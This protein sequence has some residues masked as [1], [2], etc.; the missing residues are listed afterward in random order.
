LRKDVIAIPSLLVCAGI[1]K[2]VHKMSGRIF[3][4]YDLVAI[5][6]NYIQF[7]AVRRGL[8]GSL[9]FLS[10]ANLVLGLYLTY[11]IYFI[12]FVS[13]AYLIL[14]GAAAVAGFFIP[15]VVVL[16]ALMLFWS[17][18]VSRTDLLIATILAAAGLAAVQGKIV[19]ASVCVAVGVTTIHEAVGIYGLP[20]LFAIMLDED[21]YK[22]MNSYSAAIGGTM[23]ITSFVS[24]AFV[25]PL[26]PHSDTKT[27]VDTIKSEIPPIYLSESTDRAFFLLLTG[28]RGVRMAQCTMQ[29]GVHYFIH[30]LVAAFVIWLAM[31]SLSGPRRR[32]WL[33][34]AL[35]SVPPMLLLW[36]IASDMSRW[37]AFGILNVWIV[38]AVRSRGPIGNGVEWAWARAA[39]A[40]A[41]VVL[42]FPGT[43]SVFAAYNVPSPLI[44]KIFETFLGPAEIRD[45]DRCDPT[46]RS[47]LTGAKG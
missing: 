4:D 47:F 2:F 3:L 31:F 43:V 11:W 16:A 22:T 7:G 9:V 34:P 37:T 33:A 6:I 39:S 44:E 26:I 18:S 13:L 15:F 35:A 20:L 40:V 10:G 17:T 1:V 19:T 28:F 25:I 46:W 42:L 38:C 45:F 21:R 12:L 30:P 27:I 8:V 5:G 23:I 41:V 36:P 32:R 29:H 24:E 14:K